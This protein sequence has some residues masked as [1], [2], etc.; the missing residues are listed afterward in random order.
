MSSDIQETADSLNNHVMDDG[1]TEASEIEGAGKSTSNNR[2][3]IGA[4]APQIEGKPKAK[5]LRAYCRALSGI[6]ITLIAVL[7]VSLLFFSQSVVS[8]FSR[9]QQIRQSLV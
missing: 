2:Q 7:L 3:R 4:E 9:K 6:L 1:E 8:F 5:T